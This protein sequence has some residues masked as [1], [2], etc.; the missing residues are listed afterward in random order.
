LPD[1][2]AVPVGREPRCEILEVV[3]TPGGDHDSERRQ[4]RRLEQF[5]LAEDR[6]GDAAGDSL[7][8]RA[9]LCRTV[10]P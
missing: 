7:A 9:P 1:L 5:Q 2:H 4:F 10:S 6:V 8:A 3:G